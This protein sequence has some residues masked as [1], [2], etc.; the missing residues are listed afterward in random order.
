MVNN[1]K[2]FL[3]TTLSLGPQNQRCQDH[4]AR[5]GKTSESIGQ[6][7]EPLFRG[8]VRCNSGRTKLPLCYNIYM[9]AKQTPMEE[10]LENEDI[11]MHTENIVLMAEHVGDSYDKEQANKLLRR[12]QHMGYSDIEA[13]HTAAKL[14]ARLWPL[15][16][17][18]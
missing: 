16:K 6:P 18:L 9:Q 4:I 14:R 10:F 17:L 3:L 7:I 13:E 15:F 8:P 1:S 12:V 2:L 5:Q 11:N